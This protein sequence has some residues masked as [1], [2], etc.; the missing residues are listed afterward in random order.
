[1][2]FTD[3]Y[4]GYPGSAHDARVFRNAPFFQDAEAN[5]DVVFP[6]NTHLIGDSAYP[7]KVW[8]LT[9]FR[10]KRRLTRRPW[11]NFVHSLT[12]MIVKR[13]LS[14][15][16]GR[17]RKT[18]ALMEVDNIEDAPVKIAATCVRYHLHNCL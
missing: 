5:P 11:Y 18:K 12:R 9:P 1:M 17:F 8:V 15:Y 10:D 13:C 3:V 2:L 6:R 14:L 16:K 4:C 7:L